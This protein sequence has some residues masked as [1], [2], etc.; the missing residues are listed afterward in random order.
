METFKLRTYQEEISTKAASISSSLKL[1]CLFMEVRCGK[2]LTALAAAN[3]LGVNNVLFITKKKVIESNTILN[4][5]N[6]LQP[7]FNLELINFESVHKIDSKK[8]DL[9]IVDESHSLG[10]FP[11]ASLRTKKIKEVVANKY[12]ILLTGTPTPE[13]YSQI[14]HQFW[15]SN[16]SPFEE[17]SF[18]KWAQNYVNISKKYVS[19]GNQVNDY[20]NAN[21]HLINQKISSYVLRFT[22]KEAGFITSVDENILKVKMKPITYNL[23]KKLERD[24]VFEGKNGGIILADTPVKLMQKVHQIYSG[25][26]KLE[27][28]SAKILDDSKAQFIKNRF[29]TKIAIFYKFKEELNLLQKVYGDQLTT[30]LKEFNTTNKNIALQ[31]VAGREGI[32]LKKATFLIYYNI[33]FS[34]TS[35]WQSRDRM[36]TKERLENTVYWIFS[37]GG[38]EEQI[39]KKV[40]HK[41]SFTSKH[42]ERINLPKQTNKVA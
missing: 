29:D 7:S 12:V 17:K 18:Y 36:T 23:V 4:D 39:Y 26:V 20:S 27:D 9:V 38:L 5:Y 25:T 34:A 40:Q 13:S 24:L 15:I 21:I 8:F 31:I 6:L 1:V 42:Y 3:K 11:K 16:Y 35:Y 22:Q 33:D 19:H 30:N 37:E 28:G 14:Y 41:K 32:S 2:T 10:A